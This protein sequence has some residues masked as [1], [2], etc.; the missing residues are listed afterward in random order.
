MRKILIFILILVSTNSFGQLKDKYGKYYFRDTLKFNLLTTTGKIGIG[1]TSP[2]A[3]LNIKAP[4][5]SANAGQIK[6]ASGTPPTTPETGLIN[7]QDGLLLLDSS[8]SVRDTIAT[9]EWAQSQFY[10]GTQTPTATNSTNVSASTPGQEQYMRVGNTVTVSGYIA[11]DCTSASV[12][13]EIDLSLPIPSAFSSTTQLSGVFMEAVSGV[14][15]PGHGTISSNS[16]N[17]RVTITFTPRADTNL[18]YRYTYTYQV[19]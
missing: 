5:S 18:S 13:S 19:L 9:R 2:T 17:D 1:V 15:S 16:T 14:A 4:T 12:P 7:F 10:S 11:I 6:L 8:N 3:A